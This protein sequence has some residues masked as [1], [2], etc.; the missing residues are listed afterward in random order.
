[1]KF[2]DMQYSRVD[3]G[4]MCEEYKALCEKVK[5]AGCKNCVIGAIKEHEKLQ[6][7]AASM[8]TLAYIRHSI[9]TKDE[10]YDKENQFYD[11]EGPVLSEAV[12][13]FMNSLLTSKFRPDIEE[14]YGKLLFINMEMEQKTFK[15]EIIP[16]LQKENALVTEYQ[17]LIAS[18]E[19]PYDGKVLNTSQLTPYKEDPDREVRRGAYFADGKFYMDNA[20]DLDR[21]FD[22]LV[23]VRTEIAHALGFKSFTELAYLRR[24]RNCYTPEM[25]A[26]FRAQVVEDI[27]PIV[28]SLK[29]MQAERIGLSPQEM[30]IFDDNYKYKDGNPKPMGTPEDILASGKRMY[31]EMSPETKKFIEFMYE[32]ELLDVEA[33]PGKAVGGYCTEIPE[34]KAPFIF[35]NFNGTTG[36]VDVLTHEAGHAYAAYQNMDSELLELAQPTMESCECHSMSMEFLAWPWLDLYYG[37]DTDRAKFSHLES[38]LTFIPYGCLVDHFQHVVYDNPELTPEERNKKWDELSAIYRPYLKADG[39]PFW[40]EGRSWQRQLHIYH[41]PFYYIDYCLAQTIS[42]KFWELSQKDYKN[43]WTRYN[44]FVDKGGRETFTELCRTADLETPFEDGSLK[45]IAGAAK[46]W[47]DE[48]K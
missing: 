44:A 12:Q 34:Y 14:K 39:V 29:A 37:K 27:V 35:S 41:Y 7:H 24:M 32:N 30:Q 36:D 45:A 3:I 6:R 10:F 15:P 9:N 48:R 19:I 42:L 22:E 17:K 23:K 25:V 13:E 20:G 2:N 46:A 28:C 33:K 16:L 18:A 5:N 8:S 21:I 47:L 4:A 31:S 38:S 11:T 26:K 43:A 40:G 1:M